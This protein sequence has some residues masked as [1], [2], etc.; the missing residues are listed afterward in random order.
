M[1]CGP[2][3]FQFSTILSLV[4][5]DAGTVIAVTPSMAAA[6]TAR[7][8]KFERNTCP[9]DLFCMDQSRSVGRAAR[10]AAGV[11]DLALRECGYLSPIF[12]WTVAEKY[13]LPKTGVF[14]A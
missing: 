13:T 14:D 11:P 8:P 9:M 7:R 6:A 1:P 12:W 3:Y 4:S 10:P 2:W 5:A